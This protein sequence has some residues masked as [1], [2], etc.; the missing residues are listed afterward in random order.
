M[1]NSTEDGTDFGKKEGGRSPRTTTRVTACARG[2]EKE[3]G[4]L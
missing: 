1:N 3:G 4:E 2:R